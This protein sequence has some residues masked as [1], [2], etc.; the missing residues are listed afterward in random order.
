L[1]RQPETS[2]IE[3]NI[4]LRKENLML[5]VGGIVVIIAAYLLMATAISPT[6]DNNQGV[7]NNANAVTLAPILA[8][9]GYCIIVPFAI[10]Y[11]P[12][13]DADESSDETIG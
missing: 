4:P 13:R 11:R 10:M 8:V 5:M 9:I 6:P 7:W 12:K 3:W 2:K 1:T